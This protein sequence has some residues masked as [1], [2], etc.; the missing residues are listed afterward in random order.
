VCWDIDETHCG[1]G[2]QSPEGKT[3]LQINHYSVIKCLQTRRFT[4]QVTDDKIG[5]RQTDWNDYGEFA[6]R[7]NFFE[8]GHRHIGC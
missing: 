8:R 1:T 2:Y 5:T 3:V 7:Y 4:L 6:K